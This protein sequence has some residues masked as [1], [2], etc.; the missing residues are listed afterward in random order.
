MRF[1]IEREL[2]ESKADLQ[3]FNQYF[4]SDLVK[5]FYQYKDRIPKDDRD[6]YAWMKYP[7]KWLESFLINLESEPSSNQAKKQAKQGADL[8]YSGNGWRV[9]AI[10]THSAASYYGRDATWCIVSSASS[11]FIDDS[12]D[13]WNDYTNDGYKFYFYINNYSKYALLYKSNN[14]YRIF[15]DEDNLVF[16]IE[17]APR[18][19]GLP[20]VAHR[21]TPFL[22]KK[23]NKLYGIS[24]SDIKSLIHEGFSEDF[25]NYLQI[26]SSLL[27]NTAWELTTKNG[28]TYYFVIYDVSV[29]QDC[30]NEVNQFKKNNLAN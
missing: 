19:E 25:D 4:G 23:L 1:L 13:Y 14:D 5:K 15:N 29:L 6:L 30:T 17:D 10:N 3:K 20:D 12:K 18:V 28:K 27:W 9:Y 24:E 7:P 21:M 26:D 11:D 22:M 2:N 8:L 16:Y